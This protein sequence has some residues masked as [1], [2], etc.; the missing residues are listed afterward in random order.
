V[1][2]P[3]T[4]RGPT[5]V[6]LVGNHC[7]RRKVKFIRLHIYGQD[8]GRLSEFKYLDMWSVEKLMWKRHVE[9]KCRKV[10][11]LMRAVA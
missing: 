1:D 6:P 9:I 2:S 11:N 8:I 4:L 7:T 10:L 5:V 3:S